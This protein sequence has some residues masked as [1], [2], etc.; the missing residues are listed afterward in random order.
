M[1][2]LRLG[3]Q[4][5]SVLG[6]SWTPAKLGTAP[7][8]WLPTSSL[9]G[10]NDGDPCSSFLDIS[11]NSRNFNA[12]GTAR[13]TYKAN[14]LNGYPVLRFDG[15]D[16]THVCVSST[17]IRSIAVVAKYNAATLQTDY[18]GLITG[19]SNANAA[20]AIG[21][22]SSQAKFYEFPADVTYYKNNIETAEDTNGAAPMNA[23]AIMFIISST[24]RN[25]TWQIG[26]DRAEGGR[27]WLGDFAEVIGSSAAWDSTERGLLYTYLA[28]KYAL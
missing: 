11:G 19:N 7:S 23:F 22:V 3:L 28:N 5:N 1:F 25:Y 10:L 21:S 16:D 17:S 26:S 2:G 24:A 6:N 9:T 27:R 14:V 13:A 18:P 15:T 12:S 4:T 8:Y 20:F